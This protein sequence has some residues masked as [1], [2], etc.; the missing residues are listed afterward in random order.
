LSSCIL[1][2]LVS[3]R[4]DCLILLFLVPSILNMFVFLEMGSLMITMNYCPFICGIIPV[5][6]SNSLTPLIV[7]FEVIIFSH[8]HVYPNI[9]ALCFQVTYN[10]QVP[11]QLSI[12]WKKFL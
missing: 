4:V 8:F 9:V 12:H 11:I 7:K 6:I 5:Y 1:N 10:F 2:M 3:K